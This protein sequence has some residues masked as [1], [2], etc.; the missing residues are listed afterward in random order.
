[1][2]TNLTSELIKLFFS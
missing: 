2:L 1:M